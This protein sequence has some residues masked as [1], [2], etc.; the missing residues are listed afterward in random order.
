MKTLV[1]YSDFLDLPKLF[2]LDGDL[3]KFDGLIVNCTEDFDLQKEFL[4]LMF[5][6]GSLRSDSINH[7][8][9]RLTFSYCI[10]CGFA[11]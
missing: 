8:Q 3:R 1:V 5:V 11:P 9:D 4:D 10:T 2:I 7:K 6:D